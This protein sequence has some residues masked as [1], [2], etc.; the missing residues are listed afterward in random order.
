[1]NRYESTTKIVEAMSRAVRRLILMLL[2]FMLLFIISTA[3][4]MYSQITAGR[5]DDGFPG[6]EKLLAENPDTV[7]WIRMD[8]THIDHPVV[9]GTDNF[10]YINKGFDG[11][12]YQ[13]GCIFLDSGN[14]RD[15]SDEYIILQGHHMSGGAMFSDVASYIEKDFFDANSTGELITPDYIYALT[16]VGV[17]TADA[18][19]GELYYTGP[20]VK[21]P[22]HFID[23]CVFKRNADFKDKDKLVMLSTCAGDMTTNRITLF[24]RARKMMKTDEINGGRK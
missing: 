23:D 9:K 20:K 12:Y 2:A 18:Y 14:S 10:E 17:K 4:D 7:A 15:F 24:C 3:Y 5:I 13:G 8:G 22:L 11:R 19:D 16:V 1:M 21:R 6:F